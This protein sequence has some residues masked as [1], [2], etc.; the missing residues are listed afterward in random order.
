MSES[1]DF[2][3]KINKRRGGKGRSR[4]TQNAR[5][6]SILTQLKHI[7]LCSFDKKK[8]FHPGL[9][10]ADLSSNYHTLNQDLERL[11]KTEN[12]IEVSHF[13]RGKSYTGKMYFYL[14]D[15][16]KETLEFLI[17]YEP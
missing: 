17:N 11:I 1:T 8:T 13:N 16:G 7:S 9:L 10:K 6:I 4:Q 14:S 12:I 3:F 2:D 15:K 5:T